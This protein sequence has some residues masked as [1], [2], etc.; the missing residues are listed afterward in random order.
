MAAQYAKCQL[1]ESCSQVGE[2]I[3]SDLWQLRS[4]AQLI[5]DGVVATGDVEFDIWSRVQACYIASIEGCLS[6]MADRPFESNL[7]S[8]GHGLEVI[9]GVMGSTETL[10][11]I[12]SRN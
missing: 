9:Q 5:L 4:N 12:S 8:R 10:V 7:M 6:G 3:L 1:P 11:R 2:Q